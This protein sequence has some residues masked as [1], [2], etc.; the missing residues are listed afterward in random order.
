LGPAMAVEASGSIGSV[1]APTGATRAD[2]AEGAGEGSGAAA[3]GG[4]G[5]RDDE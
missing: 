4:G 5:G 1:A 2:P 3:P